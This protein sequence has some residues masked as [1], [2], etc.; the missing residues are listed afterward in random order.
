[1][2]RMGEIT[3]N[4]IGSHAIPE[5]MATLNATFGTS[6]PKITIRSKYYALQSLTRLYISFKRRGTGMGWD[7]SKYTLMMDDGR[8]A[9]LLQVN[10]DFTRFYNRSCYVFHLLEE[11]F[12][13]QG[14]TGDYS[15]A[16]EESP[17]NTDEK[18]EMENAARSAKP[19][20]VVNVGSSGEDVK[21]PSAR[22]GKGKGKRN[23]TKEKKKRKSGGMS[24]DSFFSGS[25]R[26]FE[27][28]MRVLDSIE[29]KLSGKRG[30]SICYWF[31]LFTVE[32]Y[33]SPCG[34]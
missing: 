9:D 2:H 13:N 22:K 29:T 21:L 10:S 30:D 34:C 6:F 28:Y 32:D 3:P 25:S 20:D 26:E 33:T 1:M 15:G 12:M 18:L 16:H 23:V 5:V 27:Q 4:N 14:A 24:E 31:G 8:W 7:S 17:L 11:V 19:S